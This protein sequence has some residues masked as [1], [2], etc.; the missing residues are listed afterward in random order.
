MTRHCVM[1]PGEAGAMRGH[2]SYYLLTAGVNLGS[3]RAQ[4]FYAPVS[5]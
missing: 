2:R 3:D 4:G 1:G 5:N